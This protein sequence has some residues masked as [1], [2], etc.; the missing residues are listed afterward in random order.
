MDKIKFI[1][2]FNTYK[3]NSSVNDFF[4]LKNKKIIINK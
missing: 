3:K 1:N 2:N 4:D